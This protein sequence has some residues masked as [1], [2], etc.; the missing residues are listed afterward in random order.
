MSKKVSILS[1]LKNL[2][3][4]NTGTNLSRFRSESG[5]DSYDYG[6]KKEYKPYEHL[7]V[8]ILKSNNG[9]CMEELVDGPDGYEFMKIV[10]HAGYQI[11]DLDTYIGEAYVIYSN[12]DTV[13]ARVDDFKVPGGFIAS[14]FAGKQLGKECKKG[15]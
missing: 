11:D 4:G 5:I 3:N 7:Y 1:R 13:I 9:I 2:V 15:K 8:R 12:V 6:D 10:D 14:R